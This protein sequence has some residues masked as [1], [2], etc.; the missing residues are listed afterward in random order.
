M[1]SRRVLKTWP[2]MEVPKVIRYVLALE[3]IL[4]TIYGHL[5]TMYGE[6]VKSP[7]L[8]GVACSE[9]ET[10]QRKTKVEVG[11][12]LHSRLKIVLPQYRAVCLR[13]VA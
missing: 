2:S 4:S 7:P 9:T 6:K 1:A 8:T 5:Q 13:T 12:H 11:M 3:S 10:I